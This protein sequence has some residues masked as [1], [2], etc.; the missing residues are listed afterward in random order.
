MRELADVD[1]FLHNCALV[2]QVNHF[3]S[4]ERAMLSPHP[5]TTYHLTSSVQAEDETEHSRV[6]SLIQYAIVVRR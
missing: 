2:P 4:A 5:C 3:V 1:Q 6:L